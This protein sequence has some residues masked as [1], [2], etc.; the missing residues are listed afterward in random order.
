[1]V[2]S[3]GCS[4]LRDEG[5]FCNLNFVY[6]GLGIGKLQF[7]IKKKFS[8][9]IF[10]I[11]LVIEDLDP[12]WTRI[13]IQLKM[14]D[15]DPDKMNADPHS[16]TLILSS[17]FDTLSMYA[18]KYC[19]QSTRL[20][21]QSPELGPP[22]PHPQANVTF[23][24]WFRGMDTFA[25]GSGGTGVPIRTRGK[26]TVVL[27]VYMYS[28]MYAIVLFYFCLSFYTSFDFFTIIKLPTPPLKLLPLLAG[29][30]R[31]SWRGFV[32]LSKKKNLKHK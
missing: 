8:A 13:G 21:L 27:Q 6:G 31:T 1:M 30:N 25:C 16:A 9:V 3:V 32:I 23:P 18:T 19:R 20:F 22:T 28:V 24:L 11:I 26:T 4:L 10:L 2:W 17:F 29:R 15:P 14:L 7:L 12:D 5:F